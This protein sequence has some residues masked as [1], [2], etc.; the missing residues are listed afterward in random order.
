MFFY[1][2][3]Y[4]CIFIPISL[5]LIFILKFFNSKIRE[6]ESF[7]VEHKDAV[8]IKKKHG[9]TIWFHSASMGEFEQ[10]KPIIELLKKEND[11]LNI[12]VTFFSPSG[13]KTQNTY[14]YADYITYLPFDS[15]RNAIEFIRKISPDLVIFIRYE[16][17]RNFLNIL[18]KNNI[19]V[20]LINATQPSGKFYR[21]FF[22]TRSFIRSNMNFF[23]EIHTIS[24]VHSEYFRR[25]SINSKITTITDTRFDRIADFV[26][27]AQENLI[28]PEEFISKD[29]KVLV[30]GS[31][32]KEDEEILIP[33]INQLRKTYT[34]KIRIIFVPH[35]PN[36]NNLLRLTA[37]IEKFV[38][39][40]EII[41]CVHDGNLM[42]IK[43]KIE[44]KD[45]VVDSIGY[46]LRLYNY[47]DFA[48]IGG[49]FGNG[50][51]SVTEAAGYGLP[52]ASGPDLRKSFDAVELRNLGI[53]N[54]VYSSKDL[55]NWL[56]FYLE[57][58]DYYQKISK[59]SKSYIFE[60][61]GSSQKICKSIKIKLNI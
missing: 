47:A 38:L 52:I 16:I 27:N 8:F 60:A 42:Q 3:L 59:L 21:S 25:L 10:A 55:Q 58:T 19:P 33:A 49:A 26:R 40:S 32:W 6:R 12:I 50:I 39:L 54:V 41:K 20:F 36:Q 14:K 51:H 9:R 35:E 15:K 7:L 23:S 37:K 2:F 24:E 43:E 22:I 1:N 13:Y 34:S 57:N 18:N 31:I 17:W 45:I 11:D 4:N 48:Y 44:G 30:A 61:I 28:F 46:L 29:E 53:L 5:F 56:S